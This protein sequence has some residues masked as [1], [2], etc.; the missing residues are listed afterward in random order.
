MSKKTPL[1][2]LMMPFM[3][4]SIAYRGIIEDGFDEHDGLKLEIAV[5]C[6]IA[7]EWL[8]WYFGAPIFRCSQ[9]LSKSAISSIIYKQCM[10]YYS[11]FADTAESGEDQIASLGE[12][13][14]GLM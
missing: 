11:K 12:L 13:R 2:E 3:S 10:S 1:G 4:H 6:G 8:W 9:N 14:K 7:I 5:V